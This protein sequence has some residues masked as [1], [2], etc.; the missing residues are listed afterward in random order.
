MFPN[1]KCTVGLKFCRV[2][3]RGKETSITK[4]SCFWARI[5]V[6]SLNFCHNFVGETNFSEDER[7]RLKEM[8]LL[9]IWSCGMITP[10]YVVRKF[11][12][13]GL[14][15]LLVTP[16]SY[17]WLLN[18]PHS[19]YWREVRVWLILKKTLSKS[20]STNNLKPAFNWWLV[21]HSTRFYFLFMTWFLYD[22]VTYSTDSE[23]RTEQNSV[24]KIALL[25]HSPAPIP[26]Q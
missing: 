4:Q 14:A 16:F 6:Y 17:M 18:Y 11:K 20:Q 7:P 8:S 24:R 12:V 5:G 3:H 15:F 19:L 10:I 26:F 2:C 23:Y 22:N 13:M 1:H 21:L 9:E 25:S